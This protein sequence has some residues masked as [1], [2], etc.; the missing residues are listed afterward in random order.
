MSVI[1]IKLVQ[2]KPERINHELEY[3]L[4]VILANFIKMT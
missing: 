1:N 3:E 4:K 2:L